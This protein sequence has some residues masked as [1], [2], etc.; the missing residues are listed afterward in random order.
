MLINNSRIFRHYWINMK[1]DYF[2]LIGCLCTQTISHMESDKN[3][4]MRIKIKKKS[5]TIS[6]EKNG[7]EFRFTRENLCL[8]LECIIY[9]DANIAHSSYST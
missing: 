2:N 3:A 1:E 8:Q 7:I 5:K 9:C 4:S 6:K